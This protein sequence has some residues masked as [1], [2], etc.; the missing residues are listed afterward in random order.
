V[1]PELLGKEI[2]EEV[3]LQVLMAVELV[4]EELEHL[5]LIQLLVQEQ[6]VV[7]AVMDYHL[8]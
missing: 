8:L 7:Q 1:G 6:V 3:I 5:D 4:V 2:L